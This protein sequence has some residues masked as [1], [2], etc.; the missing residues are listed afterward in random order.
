MV[1][2]FERFG[3]DGCGRTMGLLGGIFSRCKIGSGV[4][5]KYCMK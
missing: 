3:F 5:D 4:S 2:V 1:I